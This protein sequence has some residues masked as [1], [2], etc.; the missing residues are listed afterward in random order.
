MF[1]DAFMLYVWQRSRQNVSNDQRFKIPLRKQIYGGKM[2]F[3]ACNC[4]ILKENIQLIKSVETFIYS[5]V[6]LE[7]G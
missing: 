6:A 2:L 1:C 7:D 3:P 4:K 5:T